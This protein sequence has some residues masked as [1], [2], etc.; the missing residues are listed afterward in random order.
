MFLKLK[1]TE[2]VEWVQIYSVVQMYQSYLIEFNKKT[3]WVNISR[4]AQIP[5]WNW[6]AP[7]RIQDLSMDGRNQ[8]DT[9]SPVALQVLHEQEAKILE[10]WD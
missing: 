4:S 7:G 6:S 10:A 9:Q 5:Q 1:K 8:E 3:E 2:N